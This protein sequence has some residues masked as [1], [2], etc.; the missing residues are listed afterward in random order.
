MRVKKAATPTHIIPQALI[1]NGFQFKYAFE[2]SLH[3]WQSIS[4]EDF[5]RPKTAKVSKAGTQL[6]LSRKPEAAEII[7]RPE[8]S[9]GSEVETEEDTAK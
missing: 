3:H 5:G 9:R 6:K 8:I 2:K 1:D 7:S 4:P